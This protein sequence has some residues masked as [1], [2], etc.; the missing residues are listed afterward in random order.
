MSDESEEQE[1]TTFNA[2]DVG[3]F[4]T[5]TIMFIIKFLIFLLI[6]CNVLYYI[7]DESRYETFMNSYYPIDINKEPFC[8]GENY[9]QCKGF[10]FPYYAN[11]YKPQYNFCDSRTDDNCNY[12]PEWN[13]YFDWFFYW[14]VNTNALTSVT[15][16]GWYRYIYDQMKTISDWIILFGSVLLFPVHIILCFGYVFPY[17][18]HG[19]Q[20]FD[21]AWM[22][23]IPPL[24]AIYAICVH[25]LS[26]NWLQTILAVIALIFW[27]VF[28]GVSFTY[29]GAIW[30]YRLIKY[31]VLLFL[32]PIYNL[33]K[34]TYQ[35]FIKTN[36]EN[37][38]ELLKYY[39]I[40]SVMITIIIILKIIGN[41]FTYL[42]QGIAYG[43][44]IAFIFLLFVQYRNK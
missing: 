13:E 42:N 23:L 20:V 12:V 29:G 25:T 21:N 27:W 15:C 43:M 41:A 10:N 22:L 40:Y 26:R 33:I 39:S 9:K 24:G 8:Y 7:R 37:I 32:L 4:L 35:Y 17:I 34:F 30:F 19:Y 44:V 38:H 18:M 16:N 36:T 11:N 3:G 6:G 28:T 31:K 5:N 2:G 1:E 14:I